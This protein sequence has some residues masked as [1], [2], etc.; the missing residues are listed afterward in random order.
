MQGFGFPKSDFRASLGSG[1]VLR[2]GKCGGNAD[3]KQEKHE[4]KR[5]NLLH[6][7]PR[8]LSLHHIVYVEIDDQCS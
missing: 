8:I 6:G 4:T 1:I 2:K 3:E 5:E 7:A